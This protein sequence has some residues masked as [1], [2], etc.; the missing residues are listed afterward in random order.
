MDNKAFKGEW[1][2]KTI[3]NPAYK[4][5]WVHPKIANPEYVANDQ[6]YAYE[7][8][9]AIGFDLWQVKS[10]TIFDNVLITDSLTTQQEWAAAFKTQAA[11]S[12]PQTSRDGSL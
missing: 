11:V 2:A 8:F 9:G 10:G 3:P 7:D 6:L 1:K 4:G 12:F 5:E